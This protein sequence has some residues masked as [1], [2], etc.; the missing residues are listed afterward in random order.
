MYGRYQRRRGPTYRVVQRSETYR[1]DWSDAQFCLAPLGVGW[2]VRLSWSVAAGCVPV[3]GASE[4]APWFGDAIDWTRLALTGVPKESVKDL[5]VMLDGIPPAARDAMH[6]HVMRHRMLFVWNAA[7][8]G[9]AYNM[10]MHE[11]CWRARY[12]HAGVDCN[13][14]LPSDVRG[15]V[16][17]PA[18]R[19]V[20]KGGRATTWWRRAREVR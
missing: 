18:E 11:L 20:R 10:T 16:V 8:G 6:A 13:A 12:R 14:L 2:G 19:P 7:V 17:P 15:L 4:V 5:H 3:L 9:R 1:T